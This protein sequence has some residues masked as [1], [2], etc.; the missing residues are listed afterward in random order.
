MPEIGTSGLMSGERKR[1]VA[2]RP[3]SPRLSSTLLQNSWAPHL[4]RDF[5]EPRTAVRLRRAGVTR[6]VTSWFFLA[7]G[8]DERLGIAA[9]APRR[10]RPSCAEAAGERTEE[11]AIGTSGG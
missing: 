7:E 5:C 8:F 6:Q 2:V 10:S 3:K 1:S 11:R 9:T 4:E